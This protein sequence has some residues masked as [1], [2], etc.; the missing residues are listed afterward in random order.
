MADVATRLEGLRA[1]PLP[2]TPL[3][4]GRHIT[5]DSELQNSMS[6]NPT[7]QAGGAGATNLASNPC[8]GEDNRRM[9]ESSRE[10]AQLAEVRSATARRK[11]LGNT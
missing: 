9:K 4:T 6:G 11:E 7:Y 5:V 3:G 2:V 1:A 8:D 10:C